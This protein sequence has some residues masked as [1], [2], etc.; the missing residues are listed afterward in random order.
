MYKFL[1]ILQLGIDDIKLTTLGSVS[2]AFNGCSRL[3]WAALLDRIG[4]KKVYLLIA[5][6]NIICSAIIGYTNGNY[7][8]YF[9]LVCLVMCCEGG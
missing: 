5:T 3:G 8:G 7:A 2:S 6:I 4:F 1:F 9:I